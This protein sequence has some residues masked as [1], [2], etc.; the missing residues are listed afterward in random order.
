MK[1]RAT[2]AAFLLALA[3]HPL[4]AQEADHEGE[5]HAGEEEAAP[6]TFDNAPV[7]EDIALTCSFVTECYEGEGCAETAFDL[8]IEGRAGGLVPTDLMVEAQ[9]VADAGTAEMLGLRASGAYSLSG[10]EFA[11]RHMMTIAPDGAARYTVHYADG[12]MMIS[13]LGT[14]R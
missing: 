10:G 8:S 7:R 6:L 1:M 2:H 3:A 5:D 14:C 4:G 12:P 11:A 9:I 13:Y